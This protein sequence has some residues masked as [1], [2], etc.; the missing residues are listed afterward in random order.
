MN[1]SNELEA[2]ELPFTTSLAKRTED[3]LDD[4]LIT[5]DGIE[6]GGIGDRLSFGPRNE[7][8]R[9]WNDDGNQARLER[10]T[11]DEDL[12]YV[13]VLQE[14][15]FDLL[16]SN[17]L[18]LRE[19]EDVLLTI[20][21]GEGTIGI[22]ETNISSVEP[23]IDIDSLFGLVRLVIVPVEDVGSANE[24]LSSGRVIGG[25]IVHVGD[26]FELDLGA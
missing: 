21:D 16:G 13:F 19:L 7:G 10:V 6:I 3:V 2:F 24:N 18:A 8:V 15:R 5:A 1:C 4:V 26:V 23:P 9:I 25:E 22:H 12:L 14:A 17:I 20:D 11:I